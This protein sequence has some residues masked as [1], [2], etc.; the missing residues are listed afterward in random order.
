MALYLAVISSWRVDAPQPRPAG[1]STAAAD[2]AAASGGA[3]AAALPADT[4]AAAQI[5]AP[6]IAQTTASAAVQPAPPPAAPAATA[7]ETAGNLRS[8]AMAVPAAAVACW[9]G[10]RIADVVGFQGGGLALMAVV[11]T[12]IAAAA[13]AAAHR[14]SGAHLGPSPFAG[15][16]CTPKSVV[17]PWRQA[18]QQPLLRP[19]R[20]Q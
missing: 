20:M 18:L 2:G 4:P 11:A 16:I 17:L 5:Q 14:G 3:A 10:A 6:E 9:A 15:A 12:G 19:S 8:I 7:P 1:S 13:A